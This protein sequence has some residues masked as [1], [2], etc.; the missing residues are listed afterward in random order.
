MQYSLFNIFGTWDANVPQRWKYTEPWLGQ[1]SDD[2]VIMTNQGMQPKAMKA[3]IDR[4]TQPLKTGYDYTQYDLSTE[5]YSD[6][7]WYWYILNWWYFAW[8]LAG[9]VG[10]F[11]YCDL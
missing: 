7:P 1:L 9:C 4:A 11:S 6:R 8:I 10:P 5:P 2:H 3:M